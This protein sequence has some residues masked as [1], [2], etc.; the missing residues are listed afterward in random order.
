MPTQN[1]NPTPSYD[2]P[3]ARRRIPTPPEQRARVRALVRALLQD[4]Q[5]RGGGQ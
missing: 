3:A 4:A 1:T 5:A 2:G